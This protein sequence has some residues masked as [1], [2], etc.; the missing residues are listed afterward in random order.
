MQSRDVRNAKGIDVSHHNGS[1]D[2]KKVKESG[3]VFA[4][5]KITEGVTFYDKR[6]LENY[7]KAKANGLFVGAYHFA[8]PS[9][10]DA[11][12]E[13]NYLVDTLMNQGCFQKGDLPPVLDL[14]A[15]DSKLSKA[16]IVNWVHQW[17][18]RVKE[19]IGVQPII[20]TYRDYANTYLD[21]SLK[22][23]PLWY[24]RYG[25]NKPQNICGWERWHFLQYTAAG[26]VPGIA[27]N[28]DLNEFDGT[29][30]QLKNFI[31]G[32]KIRNPVLRRGHRGKDVTNLQELLLKIGYSPGPIDGIFG[33]NTEAAVKSLQTAYGLTVDGVVGPK[34]WGIIEKISV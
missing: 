5:I 10:G 18:N 26:S 20:Y 16:E 31:L 11:I 19:R 27:S 34:T 6:F 29:D 3:Y 23:I 8:R 13:A 33:P 25:V 14:E 21:E 22:H 28:V 30:E 24:A 12:D 9:K 32:L 7:T 17:I 4:F 15:N 1:I 2:W